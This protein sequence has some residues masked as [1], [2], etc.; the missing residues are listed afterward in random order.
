M[1]TLLELAEQLTHVPQVQ[2]DPQVQLAPQPQL[3]LFID[4]FF[5]ALI[6]A[7]L[8]ET[9]VLEPEEEDIHA[10]AVTARNATIATI[11]VITCIFEVLIL[12]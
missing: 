3:L 2:L 5:Q 1:A 8:V 9:E 4:P 12:T 11:A 6:L 10:L 7:A